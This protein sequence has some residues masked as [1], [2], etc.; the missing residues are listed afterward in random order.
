MIR[1]IHGAARPLLVL[2][3]ALVCAAPAAAAP[4][5]RSLH[6][7]SA[8]TTD[9]VIASNLA[10][11]DACR[12]RLESLPGAAHDLW[13]RYAAIA[14]LE[15]AREEYLDNDR[16]GFP[17]FAFARAAGLADAIGRGETP[18]SYETVTAA[19]P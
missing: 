8:R 1:P 5:G 11:M 12:A 3:V 16:T 19:P 9:Q 14:W 6:P 15:A 4:A 10:L 7:L 13:R 2:A 18:L 17:E